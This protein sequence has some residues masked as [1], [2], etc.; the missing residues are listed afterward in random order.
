[1]LD[2]AAR[3][4]AF[5]NVTPFSIIMNQNVDWSTADDFMRD[6]A[7]ELWGLVRNVRTSNRSLAERFSN[8]KYVE[9]ASMVTEDINKKSASST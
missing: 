7:N 9:I 4:Y 6:T 2:A 3:R 5:S 8:S 1:M